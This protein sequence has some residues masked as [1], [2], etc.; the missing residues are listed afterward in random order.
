MIEAAARASVFSPDEVRRFRADGFVIARGLADAATCSRL[1]ALARDHLARELAPAEYEAQLHYPGAPESMDAPGGHTVRRLLQAYARDTAF[2]EWA[3][4]ALVAQRLRQLLGPDVRLAQ[5]HHNCVMTKHPRFG[6]LTGWHQDIRYW[7]FERPEL[8]SAWLA[9][10]R[11]DEDNG[12]LQVIPGSHAMTFDPARFDEALF[13]RED[14]DSNRALIEQRVP[15]CLQAGDVLL[16]HCRLLHAA[17]RNR[18]SQT[19]LST[20]FTYCAT[21][22]RPL[23]GTRLVREYGGAQHVVTVRVDDFE[24]EGRRY[25]SLSAIARHIT[26][27]R[28]NGWAF[29]GLKGRHGA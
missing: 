11:E 19:K 14:L 28:W 8:I 9:L 3:A 29:F 25:A 21:D 20:V 18:S 17:G 1:L 24:F 27:T 10:G 13:F 23:P 2:R 16:F 12:G 5:A 7:A 22:N 4:G 26:G 6:S 15:V